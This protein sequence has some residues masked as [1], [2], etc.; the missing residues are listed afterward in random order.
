MLGDNNQNPGRAGGLSAPCGGEMRQTF[1]LLLLP[2]AAWSTPVLICVQ[3][4][5]YLVACGPKGCDPGQDP[6]LHTVKPL[7]LS[8]QARGPWIHLTSQWIH[9]TSQWIHQTSQWI[10]QTSQWIHQTSQWIH[11][12]SQWIHQ[13]S[14]WIHQTSQWIHQSSQW[15]HQSSQWIHQ[16]SQW[17]HQSSQW[18]HQTSQCSAQ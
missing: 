3:T 5:T 2:L 9:Q 10:H 14:Q 17:I 8:Q 16:S 7:R 11:Q 4:S 13:T 1:T 15:I 12:T 6:L 18:I